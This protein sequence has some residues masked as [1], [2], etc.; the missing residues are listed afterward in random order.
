MRHFLADKG[1]WLPGGHL[2]RERYLG[3]FDAY[4]FAQMVGSVFHART[5]E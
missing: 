2:V 1:C 3:C 5:F 4:G